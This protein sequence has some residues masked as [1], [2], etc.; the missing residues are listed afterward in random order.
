MLKPLL[1]LAFTAFVLLTACGGD[2]SSSQATTPLENQSPTSEAVSNKKLGMNLDL[3]KLKSAGVF[4][5]KI[6]VKITKGDF[7]KTIETNHTDYAAS[8]EFSELVVGKYVITVQIFDGETTVAEGAGLG[9]VASNKVATVD[10]NLELKSGGLVVNVSASTPTVEVEEKADFFGELNLTTSSEALNNRKM[11]RLPGPIP[12]NGPII[13][14][15]SASYAQIEMNSSLAL[16]LNVVYKSKK[17]INLNGTSD[18]SSNLLNLTMG[19]TSILACNECKFNISYNGESKA[20]TFST[21]IIASGD[22]SFTSESSG[23][24]LKDPFGKE[25]QGRLT[26][27][28]A[29]IKFTPVGDATVGS[30]FKPMSENIE[31]LLDPNKYSVNLTLETYSSANSLL[32]IIALQNGFKLLA[33]SL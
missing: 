3:S 1:P 29:D 19:G 21:A 24:I 10:I 15:N 27:V 9:T 22:M 8:V 20:I 6:V 32:V 30:I 2:N 17:S 26:K 33:N 31:D 12:L 13:Y 25:L 23:E 7:T 18:E 28:F 16:K 11:I 4:A 5:D 14:K